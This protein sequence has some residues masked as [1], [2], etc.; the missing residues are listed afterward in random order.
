MSLYLF[1]HLSVYFIWLKI[2]I[3]FFQDCILFQQWLSTWK[4]QRKCSFLI[5]LSMLIL[6]PN[7]VDEI[8]AAAVEKIYVCVEN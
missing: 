2:C 7:F 1:N 3:L 6:Q 5:Y 4:T 8:P